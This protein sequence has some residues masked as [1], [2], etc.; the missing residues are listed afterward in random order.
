MSSTQDMT[1]EVLTM[2]LN[3]SHQ[4]SLRGIRAKIKSRSVSQP[5][6]S[7]GPCTL[8]G[9][10]ITSVEITSYMNQLLHNPNQA[11]FS[12]TTADPSRKKG[13]WGSG[14]GAGG[15]GGNLQR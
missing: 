4:I 3:S 7:G 5:S 1:R 8:Q 14:T 6:G 10:P 2:S 15:G 13:T 12:I 9:P 11:P